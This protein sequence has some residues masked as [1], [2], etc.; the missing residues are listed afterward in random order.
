MA[1]NSTIR[2]YASRTRALHSENGVTTMDS[3]CGSGYPA[4]EHRNVQLKR[5]TEI[6]REF[7]PDAVFDAGCLSNAIESRML[8]DVLDPAANTANTEGVHGAVFKDLFTRKSWEVEINH[9]LTFD[10]MLNGLREA[11]SRKWWRDTNW[12]ALE[13]NLLEAWAA[14]YPPTR[15][16]RIQKFLLQTVRFSR[17]VTNARRDIELLHRLGLRPAKIEHFVALL[18][19]YHRKAANG[20]PITI[21]GERGQWQYGPLELLRYW[22]LGGGAGPIQRLTL[23]QKACVEDLKW[24]NADI[25][26]VVS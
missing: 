18:T 23:D 15:S 20:R 12:S 10:A 22:Q 26:C 9:D 7:M 19:K 8:R 2:T 16:S 14:K 11:V 1:S 24:H 5:A 4:S 6:L 25:L 21:E 13:F 3:D 17:P